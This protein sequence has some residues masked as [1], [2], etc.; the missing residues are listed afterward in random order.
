MLKMEYNRRQYL[1]LQAAAIAGSLFADQPSDSWTQKIRRVGQINMTEHDP[2]EMDVEQWAN[3]WANLKVDAVLVSVTGIVA[4][5]PSQLPYFHRAKYLGNRDFFGDCTAALKKRNIH[6][7]ARMSPD[8]TWEEFL[9]HK[10]EWFERNSDGSAVRHTEDPRLYRTCMFGDYYTVQIP[11]IMR[12]VNSRYDID[13]IFTNGWPPLGRFTQCYC[14]Q[15]KK[16]PRAGTV[17]YWDQ[18]NDRDIFL[19]KLYDSIAKEKKPTSIYFGNLGGGI[20]CTANLKLLAGVCNWFNCDNQGRGG[21]DTPIWGASQQG[22]VCWAVMK[23]RTSTNVTAAWSTGAIRWRNAAKAPDEAKMWMDETIATGMVPW[24]H[25]IGAEK[26]M[27]EDRRWQPL[28]REYFNWLSR[29]DPHFVNRRSLANLGVVMGQRTHLFHTAPAGETISQHIDGLY[30]ALLDGRHCFDFVHEDDLGPDNLRQYSALILPN[31]AWLSDQ[32]CRQLADYADRGG[33]LLATYETSL[34]TDRGRPRADFGLSDLFG[35]NKAGNAIGTLGNAYYQRIERR[36]DILNGFVDT[37]W[38]PGA[39][40]RIPLRPVDSPV[41]TVVPSYPAY[42]PELSYPSPSHT[43]EPAVVIREKGASRLLYFP[44][45]I[46]RTLWRSGHTDLSRLIN[47]SVAWLLHGHRPV[48]VTG[49]GV[50]E[51]FPWETQPGFAVHLLNYTNPAM[52]RGWIRD[53][54]PVGE[55]KVAMRL[56]EGRRVRKVELL[57]AEKIIPFTQNGNLVEFTVPGILDYEAAAL[58]CA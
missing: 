43:D 29:H 45:D 25:F 10:P 2:V 16:L 36:H 6:V 22:R 8:L 7:I 42:P 39:E 55:Q 15:C 51:I 30:Y 33:S 31:T 3:Y 53:F 41:L 24:Y 18:F 12:E 4:F 52:H 13:S 37:N 34:Y 17:D 1:G 54:F 9:Q 50:V 56:P 27:G 21:D 47:N 58:T 46:D 20:R 35:I 49:P 48:T 57:R 19:W 23:G 11:A 5:Y 32:Q 26:G 14:E 40:H 38:I 28:G 44:G